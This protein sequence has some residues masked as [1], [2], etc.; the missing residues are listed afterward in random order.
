MVGPPQAVPTL[1]HILRAIC[2]QE[3]P[4]TLSLRRS[5]VSTRRHKRL[6][7]T[8]NQIQS[9][10]PQCGHAW[11]SGLVVSPAGST[12][13]RLQVW[14]QVCRR[15][16]R[17]ALTEPLSLPWTLPRLLPSSQG[18]QAILRRGVASARRLAKGYTS[19]VRAFT[20]GTV[21]V[22]I[23]HSHGEPPASKGGIY[24]TDQ[25]GNTSLVGC[26]AA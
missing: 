3:Q 16:R 4:S 12:P 21:Y 11:T 10:M 24:G 19:G 23:G 20:F 9:L 1:K 5:A 13:V 2:G 26:W 22:L 6:F 7:W 25:L 18:R 17:G 15:Q 8:A 14:Q